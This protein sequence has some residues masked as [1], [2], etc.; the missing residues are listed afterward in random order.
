MPLLSFIQEIGSSLKH[1]LIPPACACC[2]TPLLYEEEPICLH[3]QLSL[4]PTNFHLHGDNPLARQFWGLDSITSAAACYY[5]LKG[6]K[7]QGLMHQIKYQRN[8]AAALFIGELYGK[9]LAVSSFSRCDYLVPVPLHSSRLR[10]RGYNQSEVFAKGLSTGMHIPVVADVLVREKKGGSQTFRSRQER[11][12]MLE[13]AF[14]LA[15]STAYLEGRHIL[16]VDDV[17]TSGATLEICA[18][19]F[20][21]LG[22][23]VSI[24]A[25]AYTQSEL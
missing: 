10:Q 8:K 15:G 24:I 1:L 3:C 12:A 14:E 5:F 16:L 13:G 25:I 2:N 19:L 9:A 17:I 11:F 6:S 22:C 20:L 4:Q 23:Q 21:G 7:V 18:R